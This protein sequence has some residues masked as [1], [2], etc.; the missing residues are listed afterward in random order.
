MKLNLISSRIKRSLSC[1]YS[2]SKKMHLPTS[3]PSQHDTHPRASPGQN[4][5]ATYP[6]SSK[7]LLT[8]THHWWPSVRCPLLEWCGNGTIL[9]GS[10]AHC[11]SSMARCTVPPSLGR[12]RVAPTNMIH[13]FKF[14]KQHR[15]IWLPRF[16]IPTNVF[17][18]CYPNKN[19][20]Q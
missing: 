2:K 8:E 9:P 6:A 11:W 16:E 12:S 20:Q 17:F 4:S 1:N 15:H 18:E 10:P 7:R 13:K 5:E 14:S 3:P 19:Q